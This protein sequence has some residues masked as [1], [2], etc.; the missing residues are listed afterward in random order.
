MVDFIIGII[1]FFIGGFGYKYNP[2]LTI[3]IFL[4]VLF[5]CFYLIGFKTYLNSINNTITIIDIILFGV[6]LIFYEIGKVVGKYC[7]DKARK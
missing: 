6:K 1:I 2:V 5:I 3:I 7:K 4:S